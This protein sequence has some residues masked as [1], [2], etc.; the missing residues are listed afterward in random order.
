MLSVTDNYRNNIYAASR[1]F[2]ARAVVTMDALSQ[3]PNVIDTL[4]SNFV[5]KTQGSLVGNSNISKFR[6]D[7][8]YL[9]LPTDTGWTE[10]TTQD[11]YNKISTADTQV[12]DIWTS[13]GNL[14]QQIYQ[15]DV[16]AMLQNKYGSTI[17]KGKTALADKV[18]IAESLVTKITG[19]YKG[20]GQAPPKSYFAGF[21]YIRD[22]VNGSTANTGN[23]WVE[24]QC[25]SAG[26]NR[27][28]GRTPTSKHTLTN[29]TSI[30]DFN[31]RT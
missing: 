21:R 7:S 2:R 26:T 1:E 12:I 29:A 20:W 6:S 18:A 24:V 8:N 13:G 23:H 10:I 15:F 9:R 16:I 11:S 25:L 27:C 31:T 4:V 19:T 22:W 30:T 14:S 5:G 28:Q 17:W 3:N